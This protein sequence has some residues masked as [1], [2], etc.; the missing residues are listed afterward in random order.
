MDEATKSA[1]GLLQFLLPGFAA[2]WVFYGLSSHPKPSQFERV[3]EALIFTMFVQAAVAIERRALFW[4]G[5]RW[6]YLGIWDSDANLVNSVILGLVIGIAAAWLSH[7]DHC[8][9]IARRLGITTR[10]SFPSEWFHAFH[11]TKR[12]VILHLKDERRLLGYPRVWPSDPKCGH[13]LLSRSSWLPSE[14]ETSTYRAESEIDCVVVN[15]DDVYWVEFQ[16]N[17]G[18]DND[19]AETNAAPTAPARLGGQGRERE[20][21]RSAGPKTSADTTAPAT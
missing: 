12:Y 11:G 14:Y 2:A 1:L 16:S 13:F 20:S 17:G 10:A 9:A 6:R 21:A 15:V 19:T 7:T 5:D 3:V 8:H 18:N 4:I